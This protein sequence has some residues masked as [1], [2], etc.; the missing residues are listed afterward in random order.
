MADRL[1]R[2]GKRRDAALGLDAG[3]RRLSAEGCGER[4]VAR[5]LVDD[6]AR[7][8]VSIQYVARRAFRQKRRIERAGTQQVHLFARG[9]DDMHIRK[10]LTRFDEVANALEDGGY[11]SLVVGRED[12]IPRAADHA[13]LHH[14]F[15]PLAGAH[16]VHMPA[17]RHRAGG[18]AGAES[19]QVARVGTG[20]FR[21]II[22]ADGE[23]QALQLGLAPFRHKG[24][25]T[26]RAFDARKFAEQ[27]EQAV[28]LHRLP[29][30][31]GCRFIGMS[32]HRDTRKAALRRLS[33]MV[34]I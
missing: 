18:A 1:R 3:M 28:G 17:Q 2:H 20:P 34:H 6:G 9:Q 31:S 15:D 8:A 10:R 11:A 19:D 23:A 5:C 16:G 29:F 26:R 21:G 25:T 13:V 33:E 7:I 24:L 27:I 4:A 14:G 32:I 12:G 22:E 30:Q